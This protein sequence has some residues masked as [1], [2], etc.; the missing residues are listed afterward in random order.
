MGAPSLDSFPP[1]GRP[2]MSTCAVRFGNLHPGSGP[3]G[4]RGGY[5][6]HNAAPVQIRPAL[7]TGP[8]YHTE[9]WI[10]FNEMLNNLTCDILF[11]RT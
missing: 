10:F 3:A 1:G 7:V 8:A 5:V 2:A 9:L 11:G 6:R 4:L